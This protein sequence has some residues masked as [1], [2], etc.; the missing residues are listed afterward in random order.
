[1]KFRDPLGL[2]FQKGKWVLVPVHEDWFSLG[3][4]VIIL[5][6]LGF[7]IRTVCIT[8]KARPGVGIWPND[9]LVIFTLQPYKTLFEERKKGNVDEGPAAQQS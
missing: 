9:T 7:R 5:G 4:S 8:W 1:M 2:F 6:L 3:Q